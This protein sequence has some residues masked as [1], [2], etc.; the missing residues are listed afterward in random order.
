MS[1][2]KL[3]PVVS[4]LVPGRLLCIAYAI[5]W[6]WVASASSFKR[7]CYFTNWSGDL[8]I[9]EAH[10]NLEDI[11]ARLCSHL[12]Y[13]FAKINTETLELL[14]TRPDDEGENGELGRYVLFNNLKKDHPGLV[15]LLSVGGSL[16]ANTGFGKVVE[17]MEKR[18]KFANNC[19]AFLR[20]WGFDGLDVDWEY[21]GN[22][23]ETR[24][25]FTMLLLELRAVFEEES[26]TTGRKRL[27]L[28]MAAPV[29][30]DLI[31]QGYEIS[32]V[33]R[34]VDFINLMAY[35]FHGAW[36]HI[37]GFNAPLYSRKG[38]WQFMPDLN[39][40]WAVDTWIKRGAPA[41][42]IVVGIAGYGASYTLADASSNGVGAE[43][44]GPGKPGPY[45]VMEGQLAFYEVC[46]M[47]DK[48]EAS[49]AWDDLQ[50]VPYIYNNDTWVGYDDERSVAVKT[51]WMIQKNMGGVMLW[52]LDLD[53]FKG[54]YCKKGK[55]PLLTSIVKTVA[56][57]FDDITVPPPKTTTTTTTTTSTTTTTTTTTS[58]TTP[59]PTTTTTTSTT[60]TTTQTTT[61]AR[62]ISSK[63][64]TTSQPV[65]ERS[66]RPGTATT[67][68]RGNDV[69]TTSRQPRTSTDSWDVNDIPKWVR[70][71]SGINNKIDNDESNNNDIANI[72]KGKEGDKGGNSIVD[73]VGNAAAS[74]DMDTNA[75]ITAASAGIG[76]FMGYIFAFFS[77]VVFKYVW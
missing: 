70:T 36:N 71:D 39:V 63:P 61:V 15:T 75:G 77:T 17:S 24:T 2:V 7:V 38:D 23:P 31:T 22:P 62:S 8:L 58:T 13:A 20:L 11:D 4:M 25:N 46:E 68:T 57:Y 69:L 64:T 35:D 50:K 33:S 65:T 41:E 28:S 19:V 76:H 1:R 34:L 21:P 10:F 44:S 5:L 30:E 72:G 54:T 40:E 3:V 37:S 45:R 55:F 56:R 14:P 52:S 51:E 42:K 53:D 16:Q 59:T 73:D 18:R 27:F 49:Y 12:I 9:P 66:R 32:K 47:L 60:S 26:E 6:G 29:S 67:S 43:V 48:G 74:G